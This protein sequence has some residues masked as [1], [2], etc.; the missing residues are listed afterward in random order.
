MAT[1]IQKQNYHRKV[2]TFQTLIYKRASN[3]VLHH[4]RIML[5]TCYLDD[6]KLFSLLHKCLTQT[7]TYT[8]QTLY[9][10][11]NKITLKMKDQLTSDKYLTLSQSQN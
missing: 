1:K 7:P 3:S 2:V 8:L 10:R 9:P 5:A 6:D 11:G 4:T